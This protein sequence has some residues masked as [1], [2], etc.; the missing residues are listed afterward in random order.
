M[1]KDL[2]F[3]IIIPIYNVER[4]LLQC[5]E[6]VLNQTYTNIEVILVNDGSTDN[7]G[8]ICEEIKVNDSRVK[9]IHTD[10]KG[11]SFARNLG[12][13]IATG[14]YILFVDSDDWLEKDAIEKISKVLNKRLYDLV[15]FNLVKEIDNKLIPVY[16]FQDS[17]SLISKNELENMLPQLIKQEVINSPIKIYKT[18]VIKNNNIKF[19]TGISIAEDYLFNIEC[20]LNADSLFIMKDILYH[21]M[22]RNNNSLTRKFKENK[23][24][25]LMYVNNTI[26]EL[27]TKHGKY[28]SEKL[29]E[30]LLYIRLKNVYSCF[31]DL[32]NREC[33][34]SY[35]KKLEFIT[36]VTRLE[37]DKDYLKI[38]NWRFKILA[39]FLKNNSNKIIYGVSRLLNFYKN[40]YSFKL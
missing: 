21:Y 9:V 8:A 32:F 15:F 25:Q 11:V 22:I 7:S 10:N 2:L 37:N 17:R 24:E 38:N 40:R 31:T 19:N 39:L 34:F 20:F 26:M 29:V 36:N 18:D 4:Y 27:V 23:Y 3:S 33:N 12:I 30:A 14:D 13:N 28:N 6:S 16:P 5:L 1:G 35:K